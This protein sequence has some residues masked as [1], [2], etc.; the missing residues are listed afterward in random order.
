MAKLLLVRHGQTAGN[1]LDRYWG[2]TD[3]ELSEAGLRHAEQLRE[4]LRGY[5]INAVY[6]S[7]LKRATITARIISEPHH[8]SP[9]PCPDLDEIDFGDFEGLTFDEIG[10]RHPKLAAQLARWTIRPR[11]PG[12]ESAT[13]FEA[14]V[15]AFLPRLA[16]HAESE[17]VL[18]VAHAGT[19]RMLICDLLKVGLTHW[20]KFRLDLGSLSIVDT[21]GPVAVLSLLNDV[22]HLTNDA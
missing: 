16:T 17:T 18:V 3:V 20:R 1:S 19:L 4:R 22:S 13:E 21:H 12:G 2:R 10:Q 8:L 9:T 6:A 14:R 11:F 15:A 7:R 5:K